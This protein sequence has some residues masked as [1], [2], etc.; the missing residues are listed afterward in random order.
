[1]GCTGSSVV[2]ARR[3]SIHEEYVIKDKIGEG[4]FAQ[5]YACETLSKGQDLAV[6]ILPFGSGTRTS[7]GAAQIEGDL[8]T[9]V[10]GHPNIVDLFSIFEEDGF[11]FFIMQRCHQSL[12]HFP[13]KEWDVQKTF[14]GM[15]L[16]LQHCH[17]LQVVHRDVKLENF[18]ADFDGSVKLGDFG[19][20]QSEEM[21]LKMAPNGKAVVGR[22][23][24][25]PFMSPEMALCQPHDHKTDIWS[26]GGAMYELLYKR[27]P[28]YVRKSD[29]PAVPGDER[30]EAKRRDQRM[31]VAVVSDLN[32][33][34][35]VQKKGAPAPSLAAREFVQALLQRDK[36]VRPSS[37]KCIQLL[38]AQ[39]QCWWDAEWSSEKSSPR[40]AVTIESSEC[41]TAGSTVISSSEEITFEW[42]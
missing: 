31:H 40:R 11:N 3:R 7:Q 1:M 2:G 21:T 9:K 10:S 41:T 29:K 13:L 38:T 33:P 32:Q 5:V 37:D 23:G 12:C 34:T 39:D 30:G 8:W 19:L 20:A 22:A 26:V 25:A 16:A 35:Y 14:C 18:L 27:L 15:L 17:S 36:A 6:K 42:V 28:F 4:V 24:T